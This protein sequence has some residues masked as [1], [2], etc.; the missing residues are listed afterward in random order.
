MGDGWP[1]GKDKED[2]T[3]PYCGNVVGTK[4]TSGYIKVEKIEIES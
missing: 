3:C 1:G 2:I 4:M